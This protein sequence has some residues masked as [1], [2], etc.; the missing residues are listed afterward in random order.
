MFNVLLPVF[1]L[2]LVGCAQ[3]ADIG[4]QT[5]AIRWELTFAEEGDGPAGAAPDPA[6]WVHDLGGGGWGN[7]EPQTYTPGNDNAFY[8][9]EGHLVI[10]A[11]RETRTGEDGLEREF[12]SARLKTQGL[13]SQRYGKAEARLKV[14]R[15]QGIW[16][17]FWMLGDSFATVGW[18]ACGEIDIMENVGNSPGWLHGTLHGPGYSGGA[19]LQGSI[20][21]PDGAALADD[22]HVYGVEWDPDGIRWYVDGELFHTRTPDDARANRWAF[23]GEF[24]VILNV[25]CGGAWPGQP[26]DTT[27]FPQRMLIDYVRVYRD[28]GLTYDDQALA[29]KRAERRE[30]FAEI[31][32]ERM[33][34]ATRPS[35][36]PGDVLAVH[37][38]AGGQGVGYHDADQQNQGG[39]FRGSEGVDIGVCDEPGVD[40]SVGWTAAGE[41]IAYD[42]DAE[43]AGRYRVEARVASLG[44]NGLMRLEADGKTIGEPARIPDTGGWQ[45]WQTVS[46]GSVE[47]KKGVQTLRLVMAEEGTGP[48]GGVANVA[49]IT[50]TA[51]D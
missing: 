19:G 33:E 41:W 51:V 43:Q 49:K 26:D 34:R 12:T 47:L 42:L 7:N 50:F 1:A 44:G 11:R 29:Q 17:A 48:N 38:K 31:E 21:L 30:R 5:E 14:P 28:P 4:E 2:G 20:E 37:F 32:R 24:F 10:E 16:P 13:F 27:R 9:G 35:A 46:L 18:P 40:Y 25:A 3:T 23:D 36:V 45:N 8:D 15:G 39:L 22:F 6:K